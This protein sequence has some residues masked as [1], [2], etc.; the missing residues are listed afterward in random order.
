[1]RKMLHCQ[2]RD[3]QI[4]MFEKTRIVNAI[5]KA[6]EASQEGNKLIAQKMT[7]TIMENILRVHRDVTP[8]IEDIQ[9][10]VED[11]LIKNNFKSTAR[12][13]ILYRSERAKVRVLQSA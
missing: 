4:V 6:F 1:M 11:T 9:D 12:K 2:K 5:Y 3:G 13:Y 10:L 7:E 8:T